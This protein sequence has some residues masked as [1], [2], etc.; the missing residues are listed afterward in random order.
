MGLGGC[1]CV[2]EQNAPLL[3]ENLQ[4][5]FGY[6]RPSQTEPNHTRPTLTKFLQ[7]P[8]FEVRKSFR[9]GLLVTYSY[10]SKLFETSQIA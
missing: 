2:P 8:S 10:P 4:Q 6:A 1:Q 7:T 3:I 5:R 9:D